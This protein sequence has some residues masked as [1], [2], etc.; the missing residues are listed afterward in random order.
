MSTP[1]AVLDSTGRPVPSQVINHIRSRADVGG[2]TSMVF[3]YRA[4]AL[5]TQEMADWLPAIHSPDYAINTNRDRMV[6]RMRDLVRNDGWASGGVTTLADSIIGAHWHLQSEPDFFALQ[7]ADRRLDAVWASE[8]SEVIESE[9]RQWADDP[10]FFCDATRTQSLTQLFRTD[11]IHRIVDGDGLMLMVWDEDAVGPGGARYASCVQGINPDRLSNPTQAP[12]TKHRRGG[13]QIDDLGAPLGYHVRRAEPNDWYQSMESME[14]DYLPRCTPWGRPIVVHGFDREQRDQHRGVG[15]MA[16]V[17][18]RLK[19]LTKYDGAELKQAVIQTYFG[20]YVKSP[21]DPDQ[22]EQAMQAAPGGDYDLSGYQV[23]RADWHKGNPVRMG[24]MG[25]PLLAPGESIEKV[26]ATHPNKDRDPFHHAMLRSVAAALGTTA[27]QLT[28][29]WS[30][31][32]YSS[33]RAALLESW[34]TT[35]RRRS[36]FATSSANPVYVAWLEECLDRNRDLIPSGAPAFAEMRAA[37]SACSWIGPGRGWVDPVKERQGEVLGLD[38]GFTTLRAVTAE[39][40]GAN[41]RKVLA[42]RA[43]EVAMFKKLGLPLPDWSGGVPANVA[44]TK[45][46]AQ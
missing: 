30:K 13:V 7:R 1:R 35:M 36:D 33:L 37:Y 14:W 24:D 4:A 34:R 10:C 44:D 31:A 32:N 17:V 27:E 5:G 16:P 3:P 8:F 39:M 42:Q 21:Y 22:V 25:V 28:K 41:W 40:S 43:M 18:E 23:L 11:L 9:W 6:A 15:A 38:A 29:D 26:E 12:D 20:T 46:E 19:M 2:G 45:P